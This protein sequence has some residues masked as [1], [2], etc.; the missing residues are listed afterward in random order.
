MAKKSHLF[1]HLAPLRRAARDIQALFS[2]RSPLQ[3]IVAQDLQ[4]TLR[5]TFPDAVITDTDP[6]LLTP[7]YR[8]SHPT[9]SRVADTRS[10]LVEALIHRFVS[11]IWVDY[12]Q[13]QVLMESAKPSVLKNLDVQTAINDRGP[14]LLERCRH[15]LVD[16]WGELSIEARSRFESLSLLLKETLRQLSVPSLVTDAAQRQMI[17]DVLH[18]PDNNLRSGTTRA[19]LVDQ[20]GEAGSARLE[21]LRGIVLASPSGSGETLL[22]FTLS[23]GIE[24]FDSRDDLGTALRKR[25]TGLAPGRQMQWRLYEPR[26][27]IFDGFALSFLLKQLSDLQWG[28]ELG[29]RSPLWSGAQLD[30]VHWLATGDFVRLRLDNPELG[31]LY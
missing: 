13:G 26:S 30:A 25:L 3:V 1:Y 19:Y 4:R 9:I 6:V 23:A 16:E 15:V 27:D 24:V 20:W 17:N 14:L 22:L 29:R 18:T 5:A 11:G 2:T 8:Y 10:T 12:T 28:V 21:L 7:R 31:Q